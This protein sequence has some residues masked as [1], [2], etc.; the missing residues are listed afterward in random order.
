MALF[1]VKFF[2]QFV[3]DPSWEFCALQAGY[4]SLRIK[5]SNYSNVGPY[6][7]VCSFSRLLAEQKSS[8]NYLLHLWNDCKI[9]GRW[10]PMQFILLSPFYPHILRPCHFSMCFLKKQRAG[11]PSACCIHCHNSAVGHPNT[12]C[13]S[14]VRSVI[15]SIAVLHW[16]NSLCNSNA[17]TDIAGFSIASPADVFQAFLQL[18]ICMQKRR[19]L[20]QAFKEALSPQG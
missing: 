10:W 20:Q 18:S 14:H 15:A 13:G 11:N 17:E 4:I 2:R 12:A 6:C 3:L 5:W 16:Q 7:S 9:H 8:W 1:K 19:P